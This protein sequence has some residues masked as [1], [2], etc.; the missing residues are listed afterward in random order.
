ML[1]SCARY[2][3]VKPDSSLAV[4]KTLKDLQAILD[5]ETRRNTSYAY[6][7]DVAADYYYLLEADFNRLN[8]AFDARNI[9]LWAPDASADRDWNNLYLNIFDVNVVLEEAGSAE[10]GNLTETDRKRIQGTAHFIRGWCFF[11]LAQLFAVPFDSGSADQSLGIPLRLSPNIEAPTTR[12]SLAETYQQIITD[13]S[14]A[15][16][17]LPTSS[18]VAV[19]PDKAAAHAALARVYLIM[20]DYQRSLDHANAALELEDGLMDFNDLDPLAT[21]PIEVLNIEV[22]F[23][24]QIPNGGGGF[25]TPRARVDSVLYASYHDADLRK[26]VY[27]R[28]NADGT[29]HFK[30]DYGTNPGIPFAGL[31]TDELWLIKAECHARLSNADLAIE[32]LNTLLVT[33]WEKSEFIPY[34]A[35]DADEALQLIIAERNKELAFRAGI[36][37]SDLRRLNKDPRFAKTLTRSMGSETYT[38]NPDDARYTFL[39]PAN[40]VQQTGIEQNAR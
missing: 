16:D 30:G 10:A 14:R 20:G 21:K 9:Y 38:L 1:A 26:Q 36:R 12:S 5:N 24:A 15:I 6:A 19:R 39:I 2:L 22:L 37:W 40:V 25:V 35:T 8:D 27:Y 17:L 31:A 3:D 28:Q 29:Y 18:P 34:Q 23:H 33:R 32:S 13:L 11:Q 7:G 4:P